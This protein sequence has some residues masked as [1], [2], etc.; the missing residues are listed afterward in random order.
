MGI[1]PLPS[2]R[3]L[4]RIAGMEARTSIYLKI[5]RGSS[6]R[7]IVL[8]GGKISILIHNHKIK[9]GNNSYSGL[10]MEKILPVDVRKKVS[11]QMR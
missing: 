7:R 1:C 11:E 8:G 9:D 6:K 2:D 4:E 5:P 10:S 3:R